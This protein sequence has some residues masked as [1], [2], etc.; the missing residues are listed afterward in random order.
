[1]NLLV[2]SD[3]LLLG[4]C[5]VAFLCPKSGRANAVAERTIMCYVPKKPLMTPVI[6]SVYNMW[7]MPLK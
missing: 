5:I 1:M 4:C 3:V 7:T 2:D 6:Q